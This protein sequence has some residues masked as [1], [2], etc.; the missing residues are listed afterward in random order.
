MVQT[1]YRP[2][3]EGPWPRPEQTYWHTY[4]DAQGAFG[5]L[6]GL[7][8]VATYDLGN[9]KAPLDIDEPL[10]IAAANQ[11]LRVTGRY[12]QTANLNQSISR[13]DISKTLNQFSKN[14]RTSIGAGVNMGDEFPVGKNLKGILPSTFDE[15][16]KK[17]QSFLIN[18]ISNPTEDDI[19]DMWGCFELNHAPVVTPQIG[20]RG[21]K[22]DDKLRLWLRLSHIG[23]SADASGGNLIDMLFTVGITSAPATTPKS[24]VGLEAEG[25]DFEIVPIHKMKQYVAKQW[26][27]GGS[28]Q[29]FKVNTALVDS[30]NMLALDR[31]YYNNLFA[32]S[33]E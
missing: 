21:V 8:Q 32:N 1:T 15:W 30:G 20:L 12:Q 2:V 3:G 25:Q 33:L 23:Q 31:L 10:T 7:G 27:N 14:F 19:N 9:S 22:G 26:T 29:S 5:S 17:A 13:Y 24:N 6:I 28:Q 4:D 11:S 18:K 16:I